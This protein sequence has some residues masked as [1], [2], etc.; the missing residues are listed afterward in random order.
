MYWQ[1]VLEGGLLNGH[2][3]ELNWKTYLRSKVRVVDNE[4]ELYL[5]FTLSHLNPASWVLA[6]GYVLIQLRF[7]PKH[8]SGRFQNFGSVAWAELA[9]W[10]CGGYKI[11]EYC[12]WLY[13]VKCDKLYVTEHRW[14]NQKYIKYIENDPTPWNKVLFRHLKFVNY[15]SNYGWLFW[16]RKKNIRVERGNG[17]PPYEW[18]PD[19]TPETNRLTTE[20]DKTLHS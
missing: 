19:L 3:E 17:N 8:F 15:I 1:G 13:G 18:N 4:R 11:D 20:R 9:H 2:V 5:V 14:I 10:C 6:F 7:L 12:L 16:W